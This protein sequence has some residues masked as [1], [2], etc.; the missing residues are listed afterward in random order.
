VRKSHIAAL[1][2]GFAAL[3]SALV[4]TAVA[5]PAVRTTTVTVTAGKPAEFKFTVSPKSV[6][7]GAV[8][9]KITNK[10]TLPHDFKICS[11]SKGGTANSCKGTVTKMISP[12]TSATLKYTF[13][14]SGKYEYMCTV[15]GHAAGGMKGILKVT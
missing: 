15:P 8:T 13:K 11:S 12:K 2:A 4:L 9:F 1:G 3:A 6:K 10:G 7:H 14:S 5:F